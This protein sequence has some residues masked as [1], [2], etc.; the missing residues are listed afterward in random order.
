MLPLY[1][2]SRTSFSL[3]LKPPPAK[4]SKPDP[5]ISSPIW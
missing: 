2:S 5:I 3:P 4:Y 1:F